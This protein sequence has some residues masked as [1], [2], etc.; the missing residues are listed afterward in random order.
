MFLC[1]TRARRNS[2]IRALC[3]F[4]RAM[5]VFNGRTEKVSGEKRHH[6]AY[7]ARREIA[8]A[9]K[10]KSMMALQPSVNFIDI[11]MADR[12]AFYAALREI[13]ILLRQM[14]PFSVAGHMCVHM[15]ISSL[16]FMLGGE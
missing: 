2:R 10:G 16:L 8:L 4:L 13:T 11:M 6:A 3:Y 5:S 15:Y 12:S 14:G 7:E 1:D 9:R